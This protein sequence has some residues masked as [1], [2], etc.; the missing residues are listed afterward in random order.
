MNNAKWTWFAIG[1]QCGF[2]YLCALMVEQ[3]GNAFTGSLNV[4][5]LIAGIAALALIIY[6]L[7]RPYKEA[8]KLSTRV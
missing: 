3:F 1:D 6:M 8:T 5:G 7:F 2:A 4:L